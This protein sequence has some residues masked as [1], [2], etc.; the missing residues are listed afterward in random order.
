MRVIPACGVDNRQPHLT[1]V[2]TSMP[3]GHAQRESIVEKPKA[4]GLIGIGLLGSAIAERLMAADYDV[5]GCDAS[6]D[7]MATF[8]EAGGQPLLKHS[9]VAVAANPILLCLPDSEAVKSVLMKIIPRLKPG[10]IIIDTGTGDPAYTRK[11]AAQLSEANVELMDASVLGSSEITRNGDAALLVGANPECLSRSRPVLE[12][13]STTIHHIG[14]VG[15]GQQMK[16]VANLVLGLNRAALAEGLH[17]AE[18]FDMNLSTVLNVLRTG[19]AYSRVMDSKGWKMINSEFE[20]Q[21]R[22]SQHLKDV[23]L[24]LAHAEAARTE[25][26]LSQA[27]RQLLETAE[28]C[29]CGDL[30]NSAVIRAYD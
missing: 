22:L 18:T 4:A 19:A 21:A 6:P 7:A 27:H 16:L 28:Q 25:L 14:S 12:A 8:A 15:S 17:F 30:D 23:R 9:D 13:I 2:P 29:G 3:T 24:I 11:A 10:T 5:W 26:P 1:H 20:P